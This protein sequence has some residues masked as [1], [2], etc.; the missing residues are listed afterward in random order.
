MTN[1]NLTGSANLHLNLGA[2]GVLF[3]VLVIS[4]PPITAFVLAIG[5]SCVLAKL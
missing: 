2:F 1:T 5:A 4:F 3:G